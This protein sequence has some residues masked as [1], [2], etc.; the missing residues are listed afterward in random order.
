[1]IQL[2]QMSSRQ[3]FHFPASF[4]D[5]VGSFGLFTELFKYFQSVDFCQ[6]FLLLWVQLSHSGLSCRS[7]IGR[8]IGIAMKLPS[9]C[10]AYRK[11]KMV[12][13]KKK[14]KKSENQHKI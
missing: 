9:R 4:K 11:H 7:T 3:Q 6:D 5:K 10:I 1:M 12:S 8:A 13:L 14:F 2:V